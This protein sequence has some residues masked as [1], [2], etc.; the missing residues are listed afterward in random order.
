MRAILA[1]AVLVA[2]VAI[3]GVDP[4]MGQ[5][6]TGSR[7]PVSSGLSGSGS[8]LTQTGTVLGAS[9]F[10][11]AGMG[12]NLRAATLGGMM[13]MNNAGM[14]M[15]GMNAMGMNR[16]GMGGMGGMGMGGMGMGG[17]QGQGST[18]ALKIPIRLGAGLSRSTPFATATP[19]RAARFERRLTKLR[20]VNTGAGVEVEVRAGIATLTGTVPTDR[21]REMI[22]QLALLEPGIEKVENELKVDP[23]SDLSAEDLPPPETR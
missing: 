10:G 7:N 16:M 22:E 2:L 20:A 19:V 11:G 8:A 6:L 5:Q 3:L 4:V 14:N 17:M 9:D 18:Q 23:A 1:S 13:G 15:M 12:S 21:D